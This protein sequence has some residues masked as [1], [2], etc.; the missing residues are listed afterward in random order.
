MIETDYL[1][2]YCKNA[3]VGNDNI[4]RRPPNWCCSYECKHSR[5]VNEDEINTPLKVKFSKLYRRE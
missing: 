4:P 5:I 2:E 1:M 3:I